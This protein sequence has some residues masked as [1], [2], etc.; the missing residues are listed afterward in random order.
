MFELKIN[1]ILYLAQT[2]RLTISTIKTTMT[3]IRLDQYF[4]SLKLEKRRGF[5]LVQT[6]AVSA[7]F[8]VFARK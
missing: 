1:S 4:A 8:A 7:A 3:V 5:S 6:S 2:R